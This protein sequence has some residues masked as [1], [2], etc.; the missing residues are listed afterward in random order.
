MV[1]LLWLYYK[2]T[3]E[4]SEGEPLAALALAVILPFAFS[5][6]LAY[7]PALRRSSRLAAAFCVGAGLAE[8]MYSR[9]AAVE[10]SPGIAFDAVLA[11][12]P[13]VALF[14]ASRLRITRR[15]PWTFLLVGPIMFWLGVLL[16][17]VISVPLIPD[18]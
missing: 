17:V 11:L 3:I 4:F 9:A 8:L 1:W 7:T 14:A 15:Y 2:P 5:A 10:D 13:M 6:A 18:S 12:A 16:A